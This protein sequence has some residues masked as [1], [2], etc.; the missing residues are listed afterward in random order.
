MA[1]YVHNTSCK[2]EPNYVCPNFP[3]CPHLIGGALEAIV[4][5]TAQD[6]LDNPGNLAITLCTFPVWR[7]CDIHNLDNLELDDF[8]PGRVDFFRGQALGECQVMK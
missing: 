6:G 4:T 1:C 7:C 8:N 5:K 2:V 3:D